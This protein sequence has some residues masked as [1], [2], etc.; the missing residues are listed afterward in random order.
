MILMSGYVLN[1]VT[2]GSRRLVIGQGIS[3][4][5]LHV[6][7][8]LW[9]RVRMTWQANSLKLLPNGIGL[10]TRNHQMSIQQN[11]EN[12]RIGYVQF[13][14]TVIRNSYKAE[15]FRI[16]DVKNVQ[17]DYRHHFQSKQFS[18]MSKGVSQMQKVVARLLWIASM[19]WI[20]IF[21]LKK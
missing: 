6:L 11:V 9:L 17:D 21:L 3:L 5:V 13:A 2:Y 20:Y 8:K 15:P 19:N 14:V 12:Q 1:V 10:R 16:K 4:V 18:F 7:V